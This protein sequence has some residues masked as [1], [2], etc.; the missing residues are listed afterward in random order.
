MNTKTNNRLIEEKVIG[1]VASTFGV[2]AGEV[3]PK[4][5][6]ADD[7]DADSMEHVALMLAVE[8]AFGITIPDADANRMKTVGDLVKYVQQS[9]GKPDLNKSSEKTEKEMNMEKEKKEL[10]YES[11]I[12]LF[13]RSVKTRWSYPA[14]SDYKI[15]EESYG[16]LAEKI[17]KLHILWETVGLK[18]GDKIAIN[19]RSSSR[20]IEVFMAALTGGYVSVELFNG[21]RPADVQ[22]LVN[23][24]DS[25][26]LYTEKEIFAA[27]DFEA[28]PD[29]IAVVDMHTMEVLASRNGFAK[30]LEDAGRIFAQ[31][32][33]DGLTAADIRYDSFGMEDVCAI[34][35]TSGSTGNPKGVML[36]VRNFSWNVYEIPAYMFP[37][38]PNETYTSVLPYAHIF[39]L[40]CD[41]LI[42][43]CMGMHVVVL[44]RPPI[45]S[46]VKE[47]MQD[48]RPRI[49]LAV[50]LILSKF[51]E[52]AVGAEIKSEEGRKKLADYQHHPEFCNMLRDKVLS[53]LGG[54]IEA[55]ATGGAAIPADIEA[56]L[57]FQINMP[58]LTGYGMTECAPVISAGHVGKYKSKSCGELAPDLQVRI[59][60]ADPMQI[61]GEVQIK[62]DNVFAGYYKNPEATKAVFTEDGWFRTGDMG[63]LDQDTTLFLTGRCKNMLLSSN[64]QNIFPEEIEVVLNTL[65]Y[66]AESLIVQRGNVL[67]ALIVVDSNQAAADSLDASSLQNVMEG[68]IRKLNSCIPKYSAVGTFELRVD[69]FSKTPKGSIRRFM[70]S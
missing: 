1:L 11:L 49:F 8:K 33:P 41:V 46:N 57:A 38:L 14:V 45:P 35:Y 22:Q 18:K 53:T 31:R 58:F 25:R 66:V 67:H 2:S 47:I 27:M 70:Y 65:P 7:F 36:T 59:A 29:V 32:H 54:R 64:G 26:M 5:H 4:S 16:Q 62:G 37:Y 42:P 48:Y 23:H 20:W 10:T 24:S 63:T 30:A 34:M 28:M 9:A 61:P 19:A 39:G 60:S 15:S 3:Q 6:L 13:E 68:N 43:M 40:T 50:P 55:F 17:E 51:V 44:G 52:Y 21:F 12:K 56:L 69:P